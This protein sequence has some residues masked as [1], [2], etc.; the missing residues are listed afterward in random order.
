MKT[1][2]RKILALVAI[3]L[4]V[5]CLALAACEP[6][7]D[8]QHIC[9]HLCNTCQKCTDV[10]CLDPACVAKCEGHSNTTDDPNNPPAGGGGD[11]SDT[12]TPPTTGGEQP[13]EGDYTIIYKPGEGSGS[14][15]TD[16][17]D[18]NIYKLI[19]IYAMTSPEDEDTEPEYLMNFQAPAGKYFTGWL[20]EGTSTVVKLDAT[21]TL[22]GDTTTLIAQWGSNI[23]VTLIG[24]DK[25]GV[26]SNL[27][28]AGW[29]GDYQQGFT[30]QFTVSYRF[31][32]PG[33]S[34]EWASIT[35][36]ARDGFKLEGWKCSIHEGVI[37]ET[38]T[39]HELTEDVTFE[40]VWKLDLVADTD[41]EGSYQASVA[42]D[43]SDVTG[44]PYKYISATI[45]GQT[46][47]LV[48]DEGFSTTVKLSVNGNTATGSSAFVK[49]ELTLDGD[50]LTITVTLRTNSATGTFVR[51]K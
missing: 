8:P 24:L 38:N 2:T 42:L 43:L 27:T 12:T 32:L 29:E 28:R 16:Y 3:L 11:N 17:A 5:A 39:Q 25:S 14:D 7:T 31:F 34:Q 45:Q 47:T 41:F 19:S 50:T 48:D 44:D 30:Q 10:G 21:I 49:Y 9:R 13:V 51:Q 6:T 18:T 1:N 35:Y 4:L 40:A 26:Y 23:T 22:T 20:I 46:L 33:D 15:Y 36:V 37:H